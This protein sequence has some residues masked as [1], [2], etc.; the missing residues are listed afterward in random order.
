[1]VALSDFLKFSYP[2]AEPLSSVRKIADNLKE[3]HYIVIAD[4]ANPCYGILTSEDL[5]EHPHK[6]VIDCMTKKECIQL[7][8]SNEIMKSKFELTHAEALPVYDK[9]QFVGILEKTQ[10]LIQFKNFLDEFQKKSMDIPELK[11]SL[12]HNLYHEIRTPLNHVLGFMDLLA[13]M[14]KDDLNQNA[15][16]YQQIIHISS[17]K[18]L[19]FIN[20]LVDLSLLESG[21]KLPINPDVL[22]PENLLIDLVTQYEADKDIESKMEIRYEM[23]DFC[24][25]IVTDYRRLKQVLSHLLD[26]SILYAKNCGSILVGCETILEQEQV[27]FYIKN[28]TEIIDEEQSKIMMNDYL[29]FYRRDETEQVGFSTELVKKMTELIKGRFDI[30]V[31]ANGRI[32][33]YVTIPFT[34]KDK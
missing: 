4:H 15:N 10:I 27:R 33:A 3:C 21:E 16:K 1:M 5:I 11:T 25:T 30:G 20:D 22:N 12:L 2:T 9:E 7:D 24:D 8:D 6:L 23:P 26:I 31:D 18:F 17:K 29:A 19:Q 13:E 14:N 32:T 28:E 34:L